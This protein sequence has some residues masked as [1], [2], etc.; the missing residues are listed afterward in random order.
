MVTVSAA[1]LSAIHRHAIEDHPEE[2][3]GT[4]LGVCDGGKRLILRASVLQNL[5]DQNRERRFLVTPQQY[6]RAEDEADAAGMQLVGFYHSHPDHPAIPSA[7]DTQHALPWFSYVIVS[8]Q[9][10]EIAD[11][12][13]W[14]LHNDR[15]HFDQELLEEEL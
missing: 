14:L 15:S 3:C 4:L 5:Q 1:A 11:L 7:F 9:R 10:G 8:V 12:T 2:C 6:R 13:S